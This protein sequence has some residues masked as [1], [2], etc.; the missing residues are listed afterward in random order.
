MAGAATDYTEVL[1]L[2]ETTASWKL[3]LLMPIVTVPQILLL[4]WMLNTL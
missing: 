3:A 4:G 2:R 1:V